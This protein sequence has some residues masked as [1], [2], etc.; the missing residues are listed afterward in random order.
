MKWICLC[1]REA[2]EFNLPFVSLIAL[3]A[4][5]FFFLNFLTCF[6]WMFLV[7]W[8]KIKREVWA[9]QP[10]LQGLEPGAASA[11][12]LPCPAEL[13]LGGAGCCGGGWRSLCCL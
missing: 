7:L 6:F 4:I 10:Q 5:Y 13:L 1:F 3:T 12:C 2:D 11:P 9:A 8:N